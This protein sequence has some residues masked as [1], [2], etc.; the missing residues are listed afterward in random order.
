MSMGLRKGCF[1]FALGLVLALKIDAQVPNAS[2]LP[3][4]GQTLNGIT[5]NGLASPNG[6]P[7]RAWFEYGSTTNYGNSSVAVDVGSGTGAIVISNLLSALPFATS[8]HYRLVASNS[9]GV[10]TSPDAIFYLP[11]MTGTEVGPGFVYASIAVGD[12]DNDG[13][14]DILICGSTNHDATGAVT[15]LWHNQGNGV[16]TNVLAGLTPLANGGTVAWG[17]YDNDGYLD[18]L[19]AGR[20]NV[21]PNPSGSVC[22]LWHNQRDGTFAKVPLNLSTNVLALDSLRADWGDF[23]NDG[24][25]DIVIQG[26]VNS[27]SSCEIWR[28]LGQGNFAKVGPSLSALISTKSAI[29]DFDNDGWLDILMT[30]YTGSINRTQFYQNNRNGTF[31]NLQNLNLPGYNVG[32]IAWGDFNNDGTL[33]VVAIGTTNISTIDERAEIWTNPGNGSAFTKINSGLPPLIYASARWGDYDNDGRLDLLLSGSIDTPRTRTISEVWHNV[34]D[35]TFTNIHAGLAGASDGAVAWGDFDNDGKLD[36][37]V[38][39]RSGTNCFFTLYRNTTGTANTVPTAPPGL[40]SSH[41]GANGVI[42]AWNAAS[43]LETPTDGL[44]YN[45]RI[46]AAPGTCD[47][48]SPAANATT[49]QRYLAQLGNAQERLFQVMTNP[50]PGLYYWSVQAVDTAF[51]GSPFATES[52][53]VI[54]PKILSSRPAAG[55]GFQLDFQGISA[56]SHTLEVSPDLATW[57]V[58]TNLTADATGAFHFID[59]GMT[60]HPARYY[61]VSYP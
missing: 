37:L 32:S 12:Y 31:K 39:G 23:D 57:S 41:T 14:L 40:S 4:S 54:A 8:Y 11:L 35:G 13:K 43:D 26:S 59:T 20:T 48:L 15:Q 1:A 24:R 16:F 21:F 2:L 6:L 55:G 17:D 33:D 28:N 60:N 19:L 53:F 29:G 61:R 44:S 30:G 10:A 36:L 3:E 56:G 58:L 38:T 50:N 46:G 22:E 52:T 42:L 49:G 9:V 25:L 5:L 47:I 27:Q 51:A 45:V 34:G 7:T 18:I